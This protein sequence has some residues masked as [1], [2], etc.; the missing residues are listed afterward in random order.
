MIYLLFYDTDTGAREEWN[1]FYTPCLAFESE[2]LRDQKEAEL[3]SDTSLSFYTLDLEVERFAEPQRSI[4]GLF[5]YGMNR[6]EKKQM[7]LSEFLQLVD[8]AEKAVPG[9]EK[10]RRFYIAMKTLAKK[11]W[12]S[13]GLLVGL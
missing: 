11:V 12:S 6:V 10:Q 5:I 7:L 9:D 1:T 4:S 2:A 13:Q 8:L 3:A